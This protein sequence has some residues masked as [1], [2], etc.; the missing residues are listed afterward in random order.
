MGVIVAILAL[1]GY[2]LQFNKLFKW[3][4]E[5]VLIFV[6]TSLI[7]LLYFSGILGYLQI[8]KQVLLTIGVLFF[9]VGCFSHFKHR[10]IA[11]II[12]PGF[13]FFVMSLA[14]LWI[15]T[16]LKY[17]SN[18]VFVDDFSHW[19]RVS[20]VVAENNR[21]VIATDAVWFQDYPPGMALFDYMFFQFSGY[22]ENIAMFSHG[23]FIIAAFAS[24]FSV[25]SKAVNRY[26]FLGIS[27]FIY[28][29]IYFFGTG[30]HT[31]SVDLIVGV[32]FGIALFGYMTDKQNSRLVAIVKL[33][34]LVIVLP[35]IKNIGILFSF[36]I[37]GV[38]VCDILLGSIRGREK[39]RLIFVTLLLT[40]L[41]AL[42]YISWGAHVKSMGVHKTFSTEMSLG[43]VVKAFIPTS[44]TERQQV[45]IDNFTRR[46]FLP[47]PES[48]INRA[49]YWLAIC[50]AFVWLIWYMGKE[51][52][53]WVRFAPLAVLFGGFC[54]YLAVLLVLY[55][56]SF[57]AY[58]GPRLASLDRYVNTYLVG[59]LIVLFGMSLTQYYKK[60]R[61]RAVTNSLIAICI[62]VMLPNLESELRDVHH[63]IRGEIKGQ[64]NQD[65]EKVAKYWKV[66]ESKTPSKSHIYFVWQG[67]NG[68]ENTIFNYGIMPREGNR[69]CWSVGEPH[70]DGDVWTCGITLSEFEQALMNYDYLFVAHADKKFESMFSQLLGSNSVQDGSLFQ[71][72]KEAGRVRL[73]RV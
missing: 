39:M 8:A 68:T 1:L 23:V 52:K 44:A 17:Y 14:G 19:G 41:C 13:L 36:V 26:A 57:S 31:L 43:V 55:I 72:L 54:A 53:S 16:S 28:T 70:A 22:R 40:A 42:T 38:V 58:E 32:V 6:C 33:V 46:V 56:F 9:L 12:S 37:V 64:Q 7:C 4:V 61:D 73:L 48:K 24:L 59:V 18:F 27:I 47:Y 15:L 60:K 65:I 49:Y 30:L 62:L 20:K 63:V 10:T 50:L 71:I 35:L 11:K 25:I 45:T 29:L 66:I 67:S 21:L 69:G 2:A 3:P 51:N 34:P 5:S